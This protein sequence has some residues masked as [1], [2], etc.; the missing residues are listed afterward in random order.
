MM[1]LYDQCLLFLINDDQ[2]RDL[3]DL[4]I[5]IQDDIQVLRNLHHV[6]CT[7]R[8]NMCDKEDLESQSDWW[9][10]TRDTLELLCEFNCGDCAEC[11]EWDEIEQET[12]RLDHELQDLYIN[13]GNLEDELKVAKS[14]IPHYL[15]YMIPYIES[16]CNI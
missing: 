10:Y 1:K 12:I 14:N 16:L 15:S 11:A 8:N 6:L 5:R 2:E 13:L 4:P 3:H 9:E 7:L